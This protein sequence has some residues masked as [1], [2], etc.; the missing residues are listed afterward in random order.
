MTDRITLAA[1]GVTASY[2][3]DVR[4]SALIERVRRAEI[5]EPFEVG[6]G[7]EGLRAEDARA[8]PE[9]VG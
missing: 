7:V 4:R 1:A 5:R 3:R 8:L 9:P 2:L 6:H